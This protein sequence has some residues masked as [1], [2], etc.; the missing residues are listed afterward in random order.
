[1]KRFT[2]HLD[3]WLLVMN[4]PPVGEK[5]IDSKWVFR[6]KTDEHGYVIKANARL[7]FRGDRQEIGNISTFSLTPSSTTNR[8]AAAVA[9]AEGKTIFHFEV[10]QAFVQSEMNDVVYMRLSLGLG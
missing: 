2:L 9:C 6:W 8:V 4:S 5:A 10:E 3:D 1:M 7:F